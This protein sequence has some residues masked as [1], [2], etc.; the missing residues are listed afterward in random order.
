MA[1]FRYSVCILPVCL[2]FALFAGCEPAVKDVEKVQVVKTV[3]NA[4]VALKFVV[5]QVGTYRF[6]FELV[7]EIIFEQPS[8]KKSKLDQ[9]KIN[10]D[11]EFD[12]AIETVNSDGSALAKITFRDIRVLWTSPKGVKF[13][14]DSER[15]DDKASSVYNLIGKSYTVNLLPDGSAKVASTKEALAAVSGIDEMKLAKELLSDKAVAERHTIPG[16]PAGGESSKSVGDSWSKVA[17]G[18]EKLLPPKVFKKTYTVSKMEEKGGKNII[19][20]SMDAVESD[21]S[22]EGLSETSSIAASIGLMVDG[23]ETYSGEMTF[24]ST[25]GGVVSYDEKLVANYATTGE[26]MGVAAKEDPDVLKFNLMYSVSL[27]SF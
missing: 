5:G 22:V 3:A 12:Q 21:E 20:V 24:D 26:A 16:I 25:G 4:D 17:I 18:H 7:Q 27:E 10:I 13:D 23:Q 8:I 11:V 6:N 2:F 19:L 14:F 15:E 9:V 1:V